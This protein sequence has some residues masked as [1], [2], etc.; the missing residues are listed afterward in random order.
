MTTYDLLALQRLD[1]ASEY[2]FRGDKLRELLELWRDLVEL[3]GFERPAYEDITEVR[4]RDGAWQ[5]IVGE[6]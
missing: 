4:L 2:I 3:A 1:L 6:H 5:T